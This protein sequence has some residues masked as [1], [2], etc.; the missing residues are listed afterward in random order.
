[1]ERKTAEYAVVSCAGIG[2]KVFVPASVLKRLPASGEDVTLFT[3]LHAR[4]DGMD[5]YGF[6]TEPALALFELLISVAGVGPRT[7]LAVLSVDTVERVTAAILEKRTDLLLRAP[8]IGKKTAERIILELQSKLELSHAKSIT[9][10]MTEEAE[11]EEALLTLGYS[12]SEARGA[13]AEASRTEKGFEGTLRG[14]LRILGLRN[15][16]RP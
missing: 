16:R 14:A 7:A 6:M 15:D 10:H 11:A 5:L 8:G 2:F 12:R 4:D 9:E 3:H 1:M 13:V